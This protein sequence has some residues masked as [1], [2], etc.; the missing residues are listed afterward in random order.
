[1]MPTI[2]KGSMSDERRD[3]ARRVIRASLLA[4]YPGGAVSPGAFKERIEA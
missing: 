1:M 3:R 4:N 2:G